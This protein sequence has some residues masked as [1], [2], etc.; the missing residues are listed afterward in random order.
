MT[1]TPQERSEILSADP[2]ERG[3]AMLAL[4]VAAVL[5]TVMSVSLVSLMNTDMTDASIEYAK[6][7]SFYVAQA[8]LEEAKAHVLAAPD[9]TTAATPASGV[10]VP[11]GGGRVTYWVDAGPAAGCGAGL[12]TLESLGQVSS[13]GRMITTRVRACA[14][15]GA[16]FLA[17]LFG[18]SRVQFQGASQTYLAPFEVGTPGGGGN[19][20]SLSEVNFA[21]NEVRLNALSDEGTSMVTVRDGTFPDFALFGFSARP[22]YNPDPTAEPVPRISGAFGDL[23]KA[24]PTV[25]QILNSCGTPYACVTVGSAITDVPG[26]AQLRESNDL[27][28][29]YVRS[30]REETVPLLSLDPAVFQGQ[31]AQNTAN[32]AL[33]QRAGLPGKRDSHYTFGEFF[34]ILQYLAA[35]PSEYL[36]GT[37]YT[38]G[39]LNVGW[40]VPSTQS[41]DLGGPSG[42]VTL[43]VGGDLILPNNVTLINTHDLTTVSGRR[44]PGIVVFGSPAPGAGW[45]CGH[46]QYVTGSGRLVMCGGSRLVVDGLVYTQ[47]GMAIEPQALVDQVGAMYH[48]NRGTPNPSFTTQDATVVLRFDPLAL[49]VFGE[50]MAMLSWQELQ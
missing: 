20:G 2:G 4:L 16:P 14:V 41:V 42:N 39:T 13:L 28:H 36:Q 9:P 17:A 35:H 26:V 3:Q 45:V 10:T 15:P 48:N 29:V 19:L 11:Y 8:G 21:G 24:R 38:D 47:D 18:V 25:G 49:S 34:K 27:Q 22:D 23:I 31:A 46:R 40:S 50:G 7:R 12:K 43:A 30:L 5:V 37:I 44:T 33:N 32:A 1:P 6:T